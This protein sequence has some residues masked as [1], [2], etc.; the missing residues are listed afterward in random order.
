MLISLTNLGQNEC[1]ITTYLKWEYIYLVLDK[2][3]PD[4]SRWVCMDPTVWIYMPVTASCV[5][6]IVYIRAITMRYIWVQ[7]YQ[8]GLLP[9]CGSHCMPCGYRRA[10]YLNSDLLDIGL[11]SGLCGPHCM[12]WGYE[13]GLYLSSELLYRPIYLILNE[14][15]QKY[16]FGNTHTW[17][18][19]TGMVWKRPSAKP[20]MFLCHN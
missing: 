3:L 5:D 9:L 7:T 6:P 15:T 4:K 12:P 8:I 17:T 10:L 14:K 18:Y 16:T 1:F 11:Y 2:M 20:E 13:C 19:Q